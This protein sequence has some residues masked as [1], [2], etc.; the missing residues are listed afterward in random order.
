MR[1]VTA[2]SVTA[3]MITCH[4]QPSIFVRADSCLTRRLPVLRTTLGDNSVESLSPRS[5]LSDSARE[6]VGCSVPR[7]DVNHCERGDH[8]E[9]RISCRLY[10]RCEQDGYHEHDRH[11]MIR[12][13]PRVELTVD[14]KPPTNDQPTSRRRDQCVLKP[15]WPFEDAPNAAAKQHPNK[16]S[17][18]PLDFAIGRGPAKRFCQPT[19]VFVRHRLSPPRRQQRDCALSHILIAPTS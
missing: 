3:S 4:D 7:E 5:H 13:R 8:D 9:A 1:P 11:P 19:S 12:S 10:G 14:D 6:A 15:P 17:D 18:R 2:T 16:G